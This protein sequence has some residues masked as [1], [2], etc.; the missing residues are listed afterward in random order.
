[1]DSSNKFA[2]Q[3]YNLCSE[4]SSRFK[5]CPSHFDNRMVKYSMP[6]HFPPKFELIVPFCEDVDK[7]LADDPQ[8]VAVIHCKAGKG[9]TGTM[10]CCYLLHSGQYKEASG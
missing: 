7:W 2:L 3:V 10:I 1:M 4:M 5:Y 6:D 8:N 9:R